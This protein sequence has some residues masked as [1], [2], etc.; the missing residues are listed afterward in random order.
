MARTRRAL[1]V[2]LYGHH[3]ATLTEPRPFRYRLEWTVA[4]LDRFGT[5]A[6]PLSLSLPVG[7]RPITDGDHR[8]VSAFSTTKRPSTN[9]Y[10]SEASSVTVASVDYKLLD[11]HVG[12]LKV[13]Q[14][15]GTTAADL[16]LRL[17]GHD[18]GPAELYR[19]DAERVAAGT[20]AAEA[21]ETAELADGCLLYTSPSPR[22]RT[23]SRMPSSA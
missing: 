14:F 23:R 11:K 1:D 3:V 8:P 6:R 22:D 12:L 10:E 16:T 4:A 18:G 9:S 17:A 20:V 5:G 15:Q 13:K 2:W 21:A 7:T 19:L